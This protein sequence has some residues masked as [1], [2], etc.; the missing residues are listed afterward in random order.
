MDD[1]P[2][3][4]HIVNGLHP[5]L[6]F[7]YYEDLFSG[8]KRIK[9]DVHMKCFTAVEVHFFATHYGMTYRRSPRTAAAC[10]AR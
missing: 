6:P 10:G 1:P 5:G 9:P 8:F 2:D 4:I 3:E 7:S